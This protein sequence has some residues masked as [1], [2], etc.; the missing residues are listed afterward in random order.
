MFGPMRRRL[1]AAIRDDAS[2]LRS[3]NRLETMLDNVERRSG[4][5]TKIITTKVVPASPRE[6]AMAEHTT[7]LLIAVFSVARRVEL[8][9][10]RAMRS[11]CDDA[12]IESVAT[13]MAVHFRAGDFDRG[14]DVGIRLIADRVDQNMRRRTIMVTLVVAL[15]LAVVI[16]SSSSSSKK[17]TTIDD[18]DTCSECGGSLT[19]REQVILA[20]VYDAA[21][22]DVFLGFDTEGPV[23]V[24]PPDV[25]PEGLRIDD[26]QVL[27]GDTAIAFSPTLKMQLPGDCLVSPKGDVLERDPLNR[28]LSPCHRIERAL[29]SAGF[30]DLVC[31]QCDAITIR[32]KIITSSNY[33]ACPQ[34][35]C[36]TATRSLLEERPPSPSGPGF[37]RY[38]RTCRF[39]NHTDEWTEDIFTTTESSSSS[40]SSFGIVTSSS[41][42]DD[43]HGGGGAGASW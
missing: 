10:D 43:D 3:R 11:F 13:A 41:S 31:D 34:C 42:E 9:T 35:S 1:C 38:Q 12:F 27:D 14:L 17:S 25:L 20:N 18:D 22:A 37:K 40:S 23:P 30:A 24:P 4:C 6:Y 36:R 8:R 32:R 39:C 15:V 29:G 21:R 7:G 33:D 16:S 26:G 19:P 5:P 28:H 2:V